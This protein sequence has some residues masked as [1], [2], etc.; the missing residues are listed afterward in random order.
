M[1]GKDSSITQFQSPLSSSSSSTLQ[2]EQSIKEPC[3]MHNSD[4]VWMQFT[5]HAVQMQFSEKEREVGQ[6]QQHF[7]LFDYFLQLKKFV[8][9]VF[10]F[11]YM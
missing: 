5:S 1:G 3:G 2:F 8:W 11:G 6:I 10:C 4:A 9:L 7:A